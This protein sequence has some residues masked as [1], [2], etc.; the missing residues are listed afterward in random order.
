MFTFLVVY[1][2]AVIAYRKIVSL[3]LLPGSWVARELWNFPVAWLSDQMFILSQRPSLDPNIHVVVKSRISFS[4]FTF[5]LARQ[6]LRWDRNFWS[7]G[8]SILLAVLC[9]FR[10]LDNFD[11]DQFG[12]VLLTATSAYDSVGS[13]RDTLL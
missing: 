4:S 10:R 13:V 3:P 12:S 5:P 1:T 2:I 7:A 8:V 11:F 6:L 9:H